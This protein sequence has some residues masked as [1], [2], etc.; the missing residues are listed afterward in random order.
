MIKSVAMAGFNGQNRVVQ[1]FEKTLVAG[2]NG[3]G[4]SSVAA[5]ASLAL[6]GGIPGEPAKVGDL[7][8]HASGDQMEVTVDATDK[9]GA[10]HSINRR[11]V[12]RGGSV[13]A[14][15]YVDTIK[16]GSVEQAL[17]RSMPVDM[18]AFWAMSDRLRRQE[19]LC[20][21]GADTDKLTADE[22]KARAALS[23]ARATREG[24]EAA[25]SRLATSMATLPAVAGDATK[26]KADR[27]AL[28]VQ[29]GEMQDRIS[30]GEENA[31]RR[32]YLKALIDDMPNVQ[33]KIDEA[34]A[35]QKAAK[36]KV[37][38]ADAV[39][40]KER[41]EYE[42]TAVGEVVTGPAAIVIRE[43]A[44]AMAAVGPCAVSDRLIMCEKAL[45]AL[46]DVASQDAQK[47]R[48]DAAAG[49]AQIHIYAARE[50]RREEI[51]AKGRADAW[52]ERLRQAVGA[53]KE[54]AEI[55]EE[56]S[57]EDR[58]IL[59]GLNECLA[60]LDQQLSAVT[61]REA[62][63]T[64]AEKARLAAEK[65][66]EDEE[67]AKKAV[68]D[69]VKA[70]FSTASPYQL[71]VTDTDGV[72]WLGAVINGYTVN[73]ATMSGSERVIFDAG[74]ARAIGGPDATVFVDAG[75]VDDTAFGELLPYL[76]KQPGQIVVMRWSQGEFRANDFGGLA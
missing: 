49:R 43:A 47:A 70:A 17:G 10:V 35:A 57:P 23:A 19:I 21:F 4:K 8:R 68:A 61:Q 5:A 59:A 33:A 18:P 41:E 45:R 39:A 34:V 27:D 64:E 42:R 26:T 60:V 51:A 46:I 28:R 12:R 50:A 29:I 38:R 25:V 11:L 20:R 56:V 2:T 36:S 75:E 22:A 9:A 37:E 73:R 24:A 66:R 72:L 53:E 7:M 13:S 14:A 74:L 31:S 58:T 55:G 3:C 65:A 76:A 6:T 40:I 69:A 48:R 44:D 52:R 15:V 67:K 16:G 32:R 63:A 1:L 62:L 54:L 30:R 71:V